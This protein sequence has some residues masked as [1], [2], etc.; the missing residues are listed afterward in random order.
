MEKHHNL[1][2]QKGSRNSGGKSRISGGKS[3][4][5]AEKAGFGQIFPEIFEDFG[6][7]NTV[8]TREEVVLEGS[9]AVCCV[10]RILEPRADFLRSGGFF[11]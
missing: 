6:R 11:D 2:N 1:Q 5:R 4:I 7:K 9:F 8:L 3:R 10:G